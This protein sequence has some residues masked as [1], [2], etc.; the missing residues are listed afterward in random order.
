MPTELD[1]VSSDLGICVG[2]R[3]H[4]ASLA[5]QKEAGDAAAALMVKLADIERKVGRAQ[6]GPPGR[7]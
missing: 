6:G 3:L 7:F 5:S 1:F 4:A 2:G